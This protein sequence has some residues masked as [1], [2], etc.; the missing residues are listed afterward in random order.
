MEVLSFIKEYW[1]LITA[2]IG[3]M[4]TFLYLNLI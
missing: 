4:S 1:V 2:F 3:L